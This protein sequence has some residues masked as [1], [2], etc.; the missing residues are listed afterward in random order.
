MGLKRELV[1]RPAIAFPNCGTICNFP[2]NSPLDSSPLLL[3]LEP[4]VLELQRAG[5]EAD[6]TA[7]LH[8]AADPPVIVELL[9]GDMNGTHKHK[10]GEGGIPFV[11]GGVCLQILNRKAQLHSSTGS[12][13]GVWV[14]GLKEKEGVCLLT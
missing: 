7:L 13:E 12:G 11:T 14:E 10:K 6:L 1:K 8:Q 2:I 3:L 4:D 9:Q 5:N